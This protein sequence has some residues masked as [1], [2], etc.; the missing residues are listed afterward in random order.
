EHNAGLL[1]G[2]FREA[3]EWKDYIFREIAFA[4][5]REHPKV[6][7]ADLFAREAMKVFDNRFGPVRRPVRKSWIALRETERFHINAVS[8]G[9]FQDIKRQ[10]AA[11]QEATGMSGEGY[12]AWRNEHGLIH[13]TTNL[14]RYIIWCDKRDR[15]QYGEAS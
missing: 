7:V 9:W 10:M 8:I 4:C 3:P 2:I 15:T 5:S 13:N 6:Q 11:F 14:F 1:Y 12:L